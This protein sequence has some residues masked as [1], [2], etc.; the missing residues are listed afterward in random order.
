VRTRTIIFAAIVLGVGVVAGI[1]DLKK[2]IVL[3]LWGRTLI[4]EVVRTEPGPRGLA[5]IRVVLAG[6]PVEVVEPCVGFD[7]APGTPVPVTLLPGDSSVRVAGNLQEQVW[8][9][10]IATLL[11][12]PLMFGGGTAYSLS[13]LSKV[14]PPA[15]ARQPKV[16]LPWL[17]YLPVVMSLGVLLSSTIGLA[18]G[19]K[20]ARFQLAAT[21]CVIAG[22]VTY[23]AWLRGSDGSKNVALVLS[24]ILFG[25]GLVMLGIGLV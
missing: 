15:D 6:K 24:I 20:L 12:A 16:T 11:I 1:T 23:L 7:C 2:L 3:S 4:G 13:R 9:S 17:R 19:T 25:S 8:T 14:K 21:A 18:L 5:T 22:S 10:V